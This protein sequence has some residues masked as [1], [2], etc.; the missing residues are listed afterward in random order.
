[1]WT[2]CL[3]GAAYRRLAGDGW[4]WVAGRSPAADAE[5]RRV[6]GGEPGDVYRAVCL[7]SGGV[8]ELVQRNVEGLREVHTFVQVG[9][10]RPRSIAER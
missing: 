6:V 10:R 4:G 3:P 2:A 8:Y 1:M 5:L 9:L 7:R